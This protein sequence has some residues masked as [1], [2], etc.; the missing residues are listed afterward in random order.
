M[1]SK[2]FRIDTSDL[3]E[4]RKNIELSARRLKNLRPIARDT[5]LVA[6]AD[7]DERFD[8]APSTTTG[9]TVYGGKQWAPLTEAYLKSYERRNNGRNRR[10]GKLLNDTGELLQSFTIGGKG[11]IFNSTADAIEFGSGLA[12]A[13]GL[14][15]KREMLFEH[16]ELVEQVT[17]LWTAYFLGEFE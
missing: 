11:N 3:E 9:G 12:K 15:N 13:A 2:G 10:G 6:Q 16:P 4:L 17:E 7:V 8:T 5:A 1:P 14:Q